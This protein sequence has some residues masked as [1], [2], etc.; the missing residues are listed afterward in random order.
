M[1]NESLK[2][3]VSKIM[4]SKNFPFPLNQAM[5]SVCILANLKGTNLKVFNLQN[6]SGSLCDFTILASATNPTQARAMAEELA[7][8]FK[9]S[10]AHIYSYEG[11]NSADW[12]L[13]DT[14]DTITHIFLDATRDVYDLDKLFSKYPQEKIPDEFYF[15]PAKSPTQD[16]ESLKNYF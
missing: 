2:T 7:F 11:Y 10:G 3:E 16:K 8:Q 9:E 5:S 14:G 4:G 1:G 12:I 6:T 15:G 13:I